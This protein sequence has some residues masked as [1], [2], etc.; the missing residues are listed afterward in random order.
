MKKRLDV[1]LVERGLAQSRDRAQALI[2][3]GDV[4]VNDVPC[5]KAG[6]PIPEEA[7]IRLRK[8]DFP[9]V[10]RGALKIIAALDT[11]VISPAGRVAMDI[12]ASTGGFTQVLL[13]R[14]AEKV[15]AVDVG[16]NQMD[17]KI[18]SDP[19]VV[20]L[21]K[22]NAR[23]LEWESVGH[24]ID[25]IVMDVSFISIEKILPALLPF[26]RDTTDLAALIKPQFEV[27]R[28]EVGKGGIV[29]DEAARQAAVERV[30]KTALGLGLERRGLINSPITGTDGNIEYLAH[31]RMG[32][33]RGV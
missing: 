33:S 6:T 14:G 22:T 2:L 17:W 1:L 16:T 20:C 32:L 13:E 11:F 10:S 23:Y 8:D 12:G 24:K 9:Y 25:V 19:R 29:Q 3:S 7:A 28:D 26:F 18:R 30:T 15:V 4:L 21:E 27:G 31:F 5:T